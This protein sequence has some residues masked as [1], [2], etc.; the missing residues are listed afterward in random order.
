MAS[1]GSTHYFSGY[2]S[3]RE[4]PTIAS[5]PLSKRTKVLALAVDWN[6]EL[7]PSVAIRGLPHRVLHP[8]ALEPY[9]AVHPTAL[10]QPLVLQLESNL[11]E[12]LSRG[13]EVVNHDADVIHPLDSHVLDGGGTTAPA[14]ASSSGVNASR[15][16]APC[17]DR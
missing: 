2:R 17:L 6:H 14:T 13:R 5:V 11:D 10:D 4:P 8:D 3:T 7:E 15:R 1:R 9:H 16:P 12:E